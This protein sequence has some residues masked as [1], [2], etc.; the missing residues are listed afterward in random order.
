MLFGL[1]FGNFGNITGITFLLGQ[2]AS[3]PCT[4]FK[5]KGNGEQVKGGSPYGIWWLES[6]SVSASRILP[7]FRKKVR[8]HLQSCTGDIV[9]SNA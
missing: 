9:F 8:S 4:T 5:V 2:K 3:E 1:R 6:A 7:F